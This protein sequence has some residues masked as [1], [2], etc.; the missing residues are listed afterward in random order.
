MLFSLKDPN[1]YELCSLGR[2]KNHVKVISC[3]ATPITF[4]GCDVG[5]GSQICRKYF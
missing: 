2:T 5:G 4:A 1:H 3:L